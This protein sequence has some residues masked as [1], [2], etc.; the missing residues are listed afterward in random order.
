MTGLDASIGVAAG[1]AAGAQLVRWGRV[2][3]REHYLGG[4]ATR[5]AVRWS[6]LAR[7]SGWASATLLAVPISIVLLAVNQG[8]AGGAVIA[9]YGLASP[10]G[11][12][13]R[14]RTSTLAWTRRFRVVATV[15][16]LLTAGV[17]GVA[18]AAGVPWV[19]A[20]A[21]VVLVPVLVDVAAVLTRPYE[22]AVAARFVRQAQRRLTRVAPRVVAITGSFGKTSTKHH[23]AEL[24]G[25]QH[26]VVP[27]P[28]SFNNRAGLSRA[29]NE[30]VADDT[31]IFIAEMG[32]YGAGEIAAM[33]AWCPPDIAVVTAI[34]PVHLER[35]GSLDAIEAAKFEIT[36]TAPTVILNI[37]D[38][39]LASWVAPLSI[40]GTRVRTGGTHPGADVV[41]TTVTERWQV[42]IDGVVVAIAPPVMGIRE[43]NLAV[44]IATALELG[45]SSSDV[46]NRLS[47][48]TPIANRLIVATAPS[49]VM[50]IDDTF[51]AN[52]ASAQVALATLSALPITG[53]RVVV[54]PGMVELGATQAAENRTLG[55]TAAATGSELVIVGRTN[56]PDLDAGFGGSAR[57]FP[58]RDAAVDWVRATLHA[59]DGVLYLNDL[60]DHY[61]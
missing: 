55:R 10:W 18:A 9:A 16:G 32:T 26:G 28:R 53:R 14:G 36:R 6:R 39:R 34:G 45:L 50:V 12:G 30:N 27:T 56:A 37:D 22:E 29:I 60:P 24:L 21:A 61:P 15:A 43:S 59:G 8:L 23:V 19:G 51:N 46:V 44:A 31:T 38:D 54:T 47:H 2:L 40:T 20:V 11:L 48:L 7:G 1:V 5:F 52:P 57:R 35:M 13:V 49:G 41:V 3:Q 25:A 58:H 42:A 4:S 17:A 33:C